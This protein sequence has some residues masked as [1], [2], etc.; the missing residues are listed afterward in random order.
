M[1]F[2]GWSYKRGSTVLVYLSKFRGY[3]TWPI[4][5]TDF[6]SLVQFCYGSDS[7][8]GQYN[9]NDNACA[10]CARFIMCNGDQIKKDIMNYSLF[11]RKIYKM[12]NLG[13]IGILIRL[14]AFILCQTLKGNRPTNK[15]EGQ[16]VWCQMVYNKEKKHDLSTSKI[17]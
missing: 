13:T 15:M 14:Y 12:D 5:G 4:L 10:A 16:Y 8:T 7:G 17:L 3:S 11:N 1:W 6:R 2:W 9:G